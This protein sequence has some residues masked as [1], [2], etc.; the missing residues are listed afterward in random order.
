M[1]NVL[2][3]TFTGTNDTGGIHEFLQE[4]LSYPPNAYKWETEG[5]VV[6]QFSVFP[7]GE[8]SEIIV[9]NSV[10]PACDKAVVSALES[11]DGMWNPGTIND[12]PVPMEKEVTV[13]FWIDKT[14][15]YHTAQKNKIRADKLLNE[16]KYSRAIIIYSRAIQFCPNHE[17]TIYRRG[18]AKYYIGDMEGALHDFE[19]VAALDSHLADPMLTKLNEV[20]DYAES[21][22]QLSSFNY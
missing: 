17:S 14:E 11:T 9:I 16:G 5:T 6:L 21:E 8:L 2:E 3:P 19:R 20:A 1:M 13:V 18:L 7:S 10:S 22:L 12:R 4:N 15:M